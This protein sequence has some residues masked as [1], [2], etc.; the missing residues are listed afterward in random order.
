MSEFTPN[1]LEGIVKAMSQKKLSEE[2]KSKIPLRS[3][4]SYGKPARVVFSPL[5]GELPRP[6]HELTGKE[7]RELEDLKVDVEVVFGQTTLTLKE[8]AALEKGELLPL[9]DLCDDLVDIYVNGVKMG[10]AEVVTIDNHFGI[11]IIS[12]TKN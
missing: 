8:L 6:I 12:F 2:E 4:G 7:Q 1:E 9:D 11:K 5:L 3:R 10:R